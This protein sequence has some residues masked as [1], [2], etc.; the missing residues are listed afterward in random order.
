MH[1]SKPLQSPLPA[2]LP[3]ATQSPIPALLPPR[4]VGR[5]MAR[6][7][8]GFAAFLGVYNGVSCSL[9]KWRGRKDFGNSVAGGLCAGVLAGLPSRS[10]RGV[11]YSA[12]ITGV[13][14]GGVAILTGVSSPPSGK[15]H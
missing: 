2:L 6:S 15:T 13:I 7:A 11:L 4:P 5:S 14:T 3:P 12:A 8:V 9:E 10:A 1:C